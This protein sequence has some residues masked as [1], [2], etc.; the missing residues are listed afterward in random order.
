MLSAGV[1][2]CTVFL[3][4]GVENRLLFIWSVLGIFPGFSIGDDS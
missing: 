1:G 4:V 2:V 3:P